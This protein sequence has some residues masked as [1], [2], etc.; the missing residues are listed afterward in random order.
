M[1][2]TKP[3]SGRVRALAASVGAAALGVAWVYGVSEWKMCRAYHAPLVPLRPQVA[4]DPAA[5]KHMA[6]VVGCLAGCH[7]DEGEGGVEQVA[8]I[9]RITAPTLAW[10]ELPRSTFERG[11]YLASITCSECHGLDFRGDPLERGPSLAILVAYQPDQFSELLRTG[12][13]IGGRS[14]P[15]MS[16]MPKVDFADQEIADLYV[17][18]RGH[19]GL[20]TAPQ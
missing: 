14:I 18:L 17:F 15:E 4:G 1:R 12:R 11:R 3:R 2:S 19:H 10:G 7:G 8:G 20:Q 9:H 6:R 13:A 16:W 5:G